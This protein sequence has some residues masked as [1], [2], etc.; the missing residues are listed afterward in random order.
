MQS[1]HMPLSTWFW[2]SY[3]MTTQTPGQS[4]LQ[5]QRQLGLSCYETAFAMLHKLLGKVKKHQSKQL[6]T[7]QDDKVE[8]I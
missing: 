6:G 4:A 3:L 8:T 5:F 7:S 2:A 1:S